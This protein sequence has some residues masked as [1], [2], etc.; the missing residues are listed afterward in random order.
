MFVLIGG[1]GRT[2][3]Q[4]ALLL[5]AQNHHVHVVEDRRDVLHRLHRDLPSEIIYEGHATEV[6]VLE[7]AGIRTAD[8]VAAV[9]SND[10]DNLALCYIAR[11]KYDTPRTV[12]RINDPRNGWIF[13]KTFHVDVSLNSAEMI[14]GMIMEEI[15]LGD[16]VTL[17][18]LRRGQYVLVEEKIAPDAKGIGV[19]IKDL[20]LPEHCVIAAII[21]DEE[22][23]VPRGVTILQA[24]DEMLAVT[25]QGGA[26]QL[27]ALFGPARSASDG[28]ANGQSRA[29]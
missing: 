16:M 21:R 15:S 25:D 1:G 9:T 29:N 22:V 8:V 10:A 14:G 6:G 17:L 13:N 12:A 24:G 5:M 11:S 7:Q 4:L 26:T 27:A 19:A 3:T 20:A 2:G 28:P 18:K 23:I